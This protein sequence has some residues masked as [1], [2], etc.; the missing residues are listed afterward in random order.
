MASLGSRHD[1]QK[2]THKLI[3]DNGLV[4]VATRVDDPVT[5]EK[6][7]S[8][9]TALGGA[10]TNDTTATIFN[11]PAALANTEY[12]Q[13]LPADTKGFVLSARNG[14]KIK[15]AYALGDTSINYITINSC[16]GFEDNNFYSAQ[17]IYFAAS[18]AGETIEI[19]AYV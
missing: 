18:S 15:L 19:V 2:N 4:E 12:S 16:F 10:P 6:L 11:V 5:H 14:S 8:V 13:A 7:D 3:T 17:T 1:N 9:I